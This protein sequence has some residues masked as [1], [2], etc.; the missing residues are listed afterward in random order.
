MPAGEVLPAPAGV[1]LTYRRDTDYDYGAP[2]TCGG[3]PGSL[4][5]LSTR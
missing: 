3:K 4:R 1:S 5:A 2:R